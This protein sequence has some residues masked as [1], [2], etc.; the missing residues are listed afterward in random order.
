MAR[1][2][3]QA[4]VAK[5]LLGNWRVPG[6]ILSWPWVSVASILGQDTEPITAPNEQ[7]SFFPP[8]PSVCECTVM[9]GW[10][11]ESNAHCAELWI[12]AVP[13]DMYCTQTDRFH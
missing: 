7:V 12:K 5:W 1:P 9:C 6:L 11:G 10:M 4:T 13:F 8:P 3:M 2:E